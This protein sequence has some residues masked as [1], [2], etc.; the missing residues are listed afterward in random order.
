MKKQVL[1]FTMVAA[2][3]MLLSGHVAAQTQEPAS[4]QEA[5]K[6]QEPSNLQ[7]E[8]ATVSKDVIAPTAQKISRITRRAPGVSR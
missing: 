5:T 6:V 7:V 1:V 3:V 4:A 2:V 8:V